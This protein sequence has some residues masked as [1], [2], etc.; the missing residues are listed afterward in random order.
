MFSKVTISGMSVSDVS[1]YQVLCIKNRRTGN[2]SN[3]GG[4][5]LS[6]G[7]SSG[8]VT[9]NLDLGGTN[10]VSG[11]GQIPAILPSGTVSGSGQLTGTFLSKIGQS[12]VNSFSFK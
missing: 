5:N 11:S 10:I 4:T 9:L 6:G 12:V 1:H 3:F 8:D 2:W 7:G